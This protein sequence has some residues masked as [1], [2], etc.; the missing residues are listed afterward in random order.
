M[1]LAHPGGQQWQVSPDGGS[2]VTPYST[3]GAGGYFKVLQAKDRTLIAIPASTAAKD[4]RGLGPHCAALL[5]TSPWPTPAR[6]VNIGG[7][8]SASFTL[9]A[10][11]AED[12]QYWT[13]TVAVPDNPATPCYV[14]NL[15]SVD[16]I[17]M[18]DGLRVVD[19]DSSNSWT[20]AGVDP[21]L[22][23]VSTVEPVSGVPLGAHI[24]WTEDAQDQLVMEDPRSL[25]VRAVQPYSVDLSL[26]TAPQ[27]ADPM[28]GLLP[29]RGVAGE[30]L[31]PVG[32][33]E[34][35]LTGI[36][37]STGATWVNPADG[38]PM[39]SW[40]W[41]GNPDAGWTGPTAAA[42]AAPKADWTSQL[43]AAP[44]SLMPYEVVT[45]AAGYPAGINYFQRLRNR[46]YSDSVYRQEN[47]GFIWVKIGTT[48]N[49]VNGSYVQTSVNA[50]G[51]TVYQ[52]TQNG[53]VYTT[54]SANFT[55]WT[56]AGAT[57]AG[58]LAVYDYTTP[59]RLVFNG[60]TLKVTP[61]TGAAWGS[62]STLSW[63]GG[64]YVQSAA[65][66]I[67]TTGAVLAY[68]VTPAGGSPTLDRLELWGLS[69]GLLAASLPVPAVLVGG[70]LT[71]TPLGGVSG[72]R[73]RH[74]SSHLLQRR[75][76]PVRPVHGGPCGRPF[77]R[78]PWPPGLPGIS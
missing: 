18:G 28:F 53:I 23:Q 41:T 57:F 51:Q 77:P 26:F 66:M 56:P 30:D 59:R 38:Q 75:P 55:P 54:A 71:T 74:R 32:D 24:Y 50:A 68:C 67:G 34:A 16:G 76:G 64:A 46:V 4:A 11:T 19:S 3:A 65:P 2:W 14:L 22:N 40:S 72:G 39:A 48:E 45:P 58:N 63:P 12:L 60:S 13:V 17:V 42:P 33:I 61:W 70:T 62:T 7:N 20:V 9:A 29:L 52:Y 25:L 5:S 69:G 73:V 49:L 36:R 43:V 1:I 47:N 78:T 8:W 35:T 6:G 15:D 37:V 44:A 21:I 31:R 10:A 27:T